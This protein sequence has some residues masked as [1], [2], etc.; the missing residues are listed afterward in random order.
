M[1]KEAK[2]EYVPR[3]DKLPPAG[4]DSLR[5]NASQIPN[6]DYNAAMPTGKGLTPNQKRLNP[7]ILVMF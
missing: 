5:G 4:Y 3:D 1:G 7:D 2:Y 6:P